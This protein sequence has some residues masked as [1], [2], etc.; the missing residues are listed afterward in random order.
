MSEISS[1]ET[2]DPVDPADPAPPTLAAR[3]A[4][5]SRLRALRAERLA[6]LRPPADPEAPADPET[7]DPETGPPEIARPETARSEAGPDDEAETAL[8]EF[9]R[10]LTGE[11]PPS[12]PVVVEAAEV[13]SFQRPERPASSPAASDLER[14]PG[15]GPNL[16]WAL[17]QAGIGCLA[18]LAPLAPEELVHRLGPIGRLV[19]AAG[20]VDTARVDTAWTTLPD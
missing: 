8:H 2:R 14:L 6:R 3:L 9:L 16:V 20:W 1:P 17:E 18:D 15:V 5:R 12:A 4:E 13:L 11:L 7:A 10:A 19:P